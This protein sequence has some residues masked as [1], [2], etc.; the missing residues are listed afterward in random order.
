MSIK[1]NGDR[2]QT[3]LVVLKDSTFIDFLRMR[4]LI[5][6]QYHSL[7]NLPDDDQINPRSKRVVSSLDTTLA[8]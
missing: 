2:N 5:D 8:L 4:F 3:L 7:T 6:M 1:K